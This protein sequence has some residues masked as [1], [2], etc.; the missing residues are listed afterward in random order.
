MQILFLSLNIDTINEWKMRHKIK[1]SISYSDIDS[2]NNDIE[3]FDAFILIADYDSVAPTINKLISSNTLPEKT[4]VMERAPEIATGKMLISHGVKA[5][6][7]S[8]MLTHHYMQMLQAVI[9]AKI[10]TYPELTAALVKNTKKTSLNNDALKLI[11]NRLT[12]KEE[13]VI[14]LIL[15]G[16]TND[17]IASKLNITVRTVKAHVGSIFN[18]LHVNDRISLVLLLK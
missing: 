12:T 15:D 16:F 4:I 10:W 11:D 18:K 13:E 7:N 6:G 9:E 14:Y 17:A 5:Y 2:L 1:S 3:K 8:R